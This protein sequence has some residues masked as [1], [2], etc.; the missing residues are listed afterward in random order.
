[1]GIPVGLGAKRTRIKPVEQCLEDTGGHFK[2]NLAAG[3]TTN[4]RTKQNM[5]AYL[6][7]T[8]LLQ[9][10]SS[11]KKT[12]RLNASLPPERKAESTLE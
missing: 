5:T 7:P 3:L 2:L 4:E 1:V 10:L 8:T 12:E 6:P 9:K 11:K